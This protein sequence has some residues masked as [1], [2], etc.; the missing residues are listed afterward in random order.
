[1]EPTAWRTALYV[2]LDLNASLGLLDEIPQTNT[3]QAGRTLGKRHSIFRPKDVGSA[4]SDRRIRQARQGVERRQEDSRE[5]LGPLEQE[6]VAA[7]L[8]ATQ[9]ASEISENE[10]LAPVSGPLQPSESQQTR[11]CARTGS[12][13]RRHRAADP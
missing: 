2:N 8:V 7:Q 1:M 3:N 11:V 12:S 6:M 5:L 4:R 13:S 10:R 9:E